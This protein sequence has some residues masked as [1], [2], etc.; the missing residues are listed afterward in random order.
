MIKVEVCGLS[1]V[2]RGRLNEGG[3]LKVPRGERLIGLRSV[4]ENLKAIF[5]TPEPVVEQKS[6]ETKKDC[7]TD[8]C[9]TPID[10]GEGK[11]VPKD[12]YVSNM[13]SRKQPK[14]KQD[15]LRRKR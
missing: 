13:K 15:Y 12:E 1:I 9:L 11:C 8:F 2:A 5:V 10:G 4:V 14:E 3:L 7:G 6:C